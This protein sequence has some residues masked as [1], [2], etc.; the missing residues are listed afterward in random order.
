MD[1]ISKV[2]DLRKK[3]GCHPAFKRLKSLRNSQSNYH[4]FF[5][6]LSLL[7]AI[8]KYSK[9]AAQQGRSE[10]MQG[11]LS[12]PLCGPCVTLDHSFQSA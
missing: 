10:S 2:S 8:A 5:H 6:F 7:I 11:C 3:N 1:K 4:F 12:Q 9:D